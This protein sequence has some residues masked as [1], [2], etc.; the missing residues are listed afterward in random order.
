MSTYTANTIRL[1]RVLQAI[2]E[3]IYRAFLDADAKAKLASTERIHRQGSPPGRESRRHLQDVVHQFHHWQKP[4]LRRH[5]SR[6][7]ALRTHPL[8]RQIRRPEPAR[9]NAHDNHL[10]A[11][12]LLYRIELQAGSS[13][14]GNSHRGVLSWLAGIADAAGETRR[15]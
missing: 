6:I 9:R 11:G 12:V 15:G 8:Y 13:A 14:R 1:H 5:L 4:L 7:E 2:P 10:E 3:K